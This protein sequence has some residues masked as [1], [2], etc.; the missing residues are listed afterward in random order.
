MIKKSL[1]GASA[2]P[3]RNNK[4]QALKLVKRSKSNKKSQALFAN[5]PF[6]LDKIFAEL[7]KIYD[8]VLPLSAAHRRDLP[9]AIRDLS[10]VL[11][12]ERGLLARPY[13]STARSIS[14]Y[15]RYF[16]SWN[17]VRL[18][19]LIPN[20]EIE[21]PKDNDLIIDIGSGPLS[22]I[23]A[24][25]MA[26]PKWRNLKLRIICV[27][28]SGQ[29][30][31]YGRSI[32]R[33]IAKST[34]WDISLMRGQI[35]RI[36]PKI[37]EKAYLVVGAN[38][39]NELC[40]AKVRSQEDLHLSDKV[41]NLAE[42]LS[43]LS[44]NI[45]FVEPGNRLGGTLTAQLR[46]S[47]S[48]F[49]YVAGSPCTHMQDCPLQRVAGQERSGWCHAVFSSSESPWWL[50]E[51]SR[52]AKLQK[53]TL[54]LSHIFMS[55]NAKVNKAETGTC[56]GR[57]VSDA[58]AVPSLGLCCYVCTENGLALVPGL[59]DDIGARVKLKLEK[60]YKTDYKSKAKIMNLA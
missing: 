56:F 9:Y 39:M 1:G 5:I 16:L 48:D 22:F 14:A 36:L 53:H 42:S 52:S 23:I 38:V 59:D 60:S 46:A 4:P 49:G 54:S 58:F 27:D 51:L 26:K 41:D 37:R 40:E 57:I 50:Y 32:F 10:A 2:R 17:L 24:L 11:T 30:M 33:L 12:S 45:F 8:E 3:K 34:N 55:R 7:P 13:F 25:Y 43:Y 44:D 31:E 29:I 6:E 19:K 18:S 35:H 20:I 47:L 28:N 15:I 21:D